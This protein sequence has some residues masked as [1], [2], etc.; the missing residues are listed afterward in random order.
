MG[1]IESDRLGVGKGREG[2]GLD[3]GENELGVFV[4]I[5]L[6]RREDGGEEG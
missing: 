5:E 1:E 2:L 3:D 6:G 4:L